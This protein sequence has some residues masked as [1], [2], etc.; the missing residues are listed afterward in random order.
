MKQIVNVHDFSLYTTYHTSF[1]PDLLTRCASTSSLK[2]FPHQQRPRSD[3]F[4]ARDAR[5][6]VD[7]LVHLNRCFSW[8]RTWPTTDLP[9]F[10]WRVYFS[11]PDTSAEGTVC[12][13][14]RLILACHA[15]AA[16]F[17]LL[18][19]LAWE[20]VLQGGRISPPCSLVSLSVC[21]QLHSTDQQ[22]EHTHTVIGIQIGLL[23]T[24][25]ALSHG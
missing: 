9:N 4:T 6:L 18:V 1:W 14:P 17:S 3:V 16:M 13:W 8:A 22:L 20:P 24:D 19:C 5:T 2:I 15:T 7:K 23:C 10:T 21:A 12:G 11:S 25:W